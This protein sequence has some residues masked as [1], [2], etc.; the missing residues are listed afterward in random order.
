MIKMKTEKMR[1]VIL[2][3]FDIFVKRM[4]KCP[5]AIG[6]FNFVLLTPKTLFDVIATRKGQVFEKENQ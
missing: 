3:R 1:K 5:F 2:P 6:V 4:T